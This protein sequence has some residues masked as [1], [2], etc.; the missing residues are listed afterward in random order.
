M[1]RLE[2]HAY[3]YDVLVGMPQSVPVRPMSGGLKETRG[4]PF[5]RARVSVRRAEE[6]AAGR[7]GAPHE[8]RLEGGARCA[9]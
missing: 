8:W 3:P 4:A 5:R 1:R 9:V 6:Y 7:A 2:G